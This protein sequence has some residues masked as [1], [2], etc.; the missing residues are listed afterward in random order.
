MGYVLA[1]SIE[2]H[3]WLMELRDSDP[4]AARRV[5]EALT[6]L[7]SEGSS[8]GPPLV[9]PATPYPRQPDLAEALGRAHQLG[10]A[11]MQLG[12]RRVADAVTVAERLRRQV[13]ALE[14]LRAK[15]D[16]QPQRALGAGQQALADQV[17]GE[18]AAAQD[19]LAEL[20][21]RLAEVSR[22]ER[23]VTEAS[24]REIQQVEAFSARKEVL[25]ARLVAAQAEPPLP[26]AFAAG[27]DAGDP[28]QQDEEPGGAAVRLGRV[29][30]EIERELR[31]LPWAEG[32]GDLR[33]Q[34][35]LMQLRPGTPSAGDIR[36]L[37]GVE[38]PGTALLLAVL[39]GRDAVRDHFGEA[40]SLSS[41]V[42]RRTS[43]AS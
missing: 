37:F 27:P 23:K 3:D 2:T 22:T 43:A 25:R 20:R 30:E 19:Q 17:V 12:R 16:D 34:T 41:E 26:E 29:E 35:G 28:G 6:A 21:Q 36:I 40:V 38:P 24:R 8:L 4:P 1:M 39:E 18:Q 32:A 9:T 33:P 31:A 15:L 7:I 10:L 14:A 5:G 42:L 11:R 13:E